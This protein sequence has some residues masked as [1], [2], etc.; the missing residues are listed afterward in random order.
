[1]AGDWALDLFAGQ[2]SRPH[3]DLE[4]AVPAGQFPER[5]GLTRRTFSRYFAD[6]R[7]VLF[8]GSEQLLEAL[9]AAIGRAGPTRPSPRSQPC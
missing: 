2:E 1:M 5:A 4:I 8:A 9:A 7:D 3:A 6:K